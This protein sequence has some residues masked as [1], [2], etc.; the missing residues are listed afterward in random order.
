MRIK[1]WIIPFLFLLACGL[2]ESCFAANTVNSCQSPLLTHDDASI[3]REFQN[4]YQCM[5]LPISSTTISSLTITSGTVK[6]LTVTNI[7]GVAYSTGTVIQI[8]NFSSATLFSTTNTAFTDTNITASITPHS[9]SNKILV[10]V[11][12][13]FRYTAGSVGLTSFWTLTRAGANVGDATNGLGRVQSLIASASGDTEELAAF[14]YLDSP[15]ATSATIYTVQIRV[16][17]SGTVY[18]PNAGTC[19]MTLMEIIP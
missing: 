3:E 12:G 6:N 11:S 2:A 14:I 16:G 18:F 5:S 9:A 13:H 17:A 7:N 8:K 4:A 19:S 15:N 10:M 1:H